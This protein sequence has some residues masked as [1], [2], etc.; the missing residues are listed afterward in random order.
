MKKTTLF[1]GMLCAMMLFGGQAKAQLNKNPDKFLGNIT[2]RG[3][4]NGGGYEFKSK[5]N[6]LTCENETKWSSV[7]GGGPNSWNWGGAD[8]AYNYCKNN[9]LLFKFHCLAWGS[10]YPSW[11]EGLTP[12]ERYKAIV[13]W[14]DAV[15]KRYP[16][17]KM[18]DVV[19]E[20]V[21]GHQ[22]GTHFFEEA[23]GGKGVSGWDWIINAFE[24][25]HERWP[26]AI[27]IYNDFNT[28]QWQHQQFIDLCVAL[29]DYGAPI[30][31]YGCQSHDL[32]GYGLNSFR[33]TCDNLHNKI[34]LPM[35][36]TEYDIGTDDD[37][38]QLTNYKEQ[39]PYMWEKDYFAGLTLWGSTYGATWTTNG[40]SGILNKNGK[41]RPAYD[42][43]VEYM[44]SEKART[45]KSPFPGMKK[46]VDLYIKPMQPRFSVGSTGK[47]D[48]RARMVDKKRKIERID[49]YAN[50]QLYC[51]LTEAPWVVDYTPAKQGTIP[52]K[53]VLTADDGQTYERVGN[54]VVVA[55]RTP[56][57]SYSMPGTVQAE[58]FDKGVEGDA[59][60]DS[61]YSNSGNKAYRNDTGVD[62]SN[63]TSGQSV[64]HTVTGEW[65]EYTINVKEAGLYSFE[66][67]ASAGV[68]DAL[69]SLSVKQED[70]TY[71]KVTDNIAVPCAKKGSW[72][73][74][75]AVYGRMTEELSAGK[76]VFR[77]NIEKGGAYID[78]F[79]FKKADLN[80]DIVLDVKLSEEKTFTTDTVTISVDADAK[81]KALKTV[82]VYV[83]N[84]K[85]KTF[86]EAPYSFEYIPTK[87]GE[88]EVMAFATDEEDKV[89]PLYSKILKV[90]KK[91]IPYKA[92]LPVVPGDVIQAENFDKM[93]EGY[94]FH[95]SDDVDEGKTTYRS[96]NEGVD[97]MKGNGGYIIGSTKANE[98]LDYTVDVKTEG[99]YDISLTVSTNTER[100]QYQV[101]LVD[102]EGNET[103][104]SGKKYIAAYKSWDTYKTITAT[105]TGVIPAGKQVL[106]VKVLS[107]FNF[108]KFELTINQEKTDEVGIVTLQPERIYTYTVYT[109]DGAQVGQVKAT[110]AEVSQKVADL[111]KKAGAYVVKN[112]NTGESKTL[113]VK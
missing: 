69:V 41:N 26:D 22:S 13:N 61:D 87:D 58:N 75:Y 96:D 72:T 47:I 91:R 48:L 4:V 60:H 76:Q 25:A 34:Q 102:E 101:F 32:T 28:F 10:Q 98:W 97:I 74:Y 44:A 1:A 37:N 99:I 63:A 8:N 5:W 108:D 2:T 81:D 73:K 54:V 3:S 38:Q 42:W 78:K 82:V 89:S 92:T 85:Q 103:A 71:K 6:Q 57:G 62:F 110:E 59:F 80:N 11:I 55:A 84:V 23:L 105:L 94:S 83:D 50:N 49:F 67:T 17:I 86:S 29:R 93:G 79:V 27:L 53:A 64:S 45:A 88:L 65:L 46:Q 9:G 12:E 111:T 56:Y 24:L 109:L 113:M 15:K 106:R 70:G 39:I 90:A 31:A 107:P 36:S 51:T 20:A 104:I 30:D 33:Q 40:N 68:E 66:M 18:F 77:L 19:N 21:Q 52:L 16:D 7:Q 14:M 95:D 100:G 35:Y 112:D 43:L